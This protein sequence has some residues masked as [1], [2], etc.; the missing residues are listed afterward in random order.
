MMWLREGAKVHTDIFSAVFDAMHRHGKP[1]LDV[2]GQGGDDH[3]SPVAFQVIHGHAQGVDAVFELFD[4]VF[5]VA[6]FVGSK[7]DLGRGEVVARGDVEE[8]PDIVEEGLLAF[9]LGDVFSQGHDAVGPFA[10]AGL[11]VKLCHVF[12][13][14]RQLEVAPR[15]DDALLL[16]VPSAPLLWRDRPVQALPGPSSSASARF[17][18]VLLQSMPK[19][20]STS[21]AQPSKWAVSEKSVSPRRHTRPAWGFTSFMAASIQRAAPW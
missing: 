20:K 21:L 4:D 9:R 17:R 1:R 16:I 10:L 19:M 18:K 5:L 11:I 2:P 3:V 13:L 8:I 14:L 7:D 15:L 12:E 6:A